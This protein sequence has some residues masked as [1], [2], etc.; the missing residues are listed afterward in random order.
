MFSLIR[1]S[2]AYTHNM[3]PA[4]LVLQDV[5][6]PPGQHMGEW[7]RQ[8]GLRAYRRARNRRHV[9]KEVLTEW[10]FTFNSPQGA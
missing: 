8:E 5:A 10:L 4:G 7:W 3:R 1:E 2:C 9:W 6:S